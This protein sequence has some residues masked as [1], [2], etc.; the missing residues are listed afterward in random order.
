MV[1]AATLAAGMVTPMGRAA[2]MGAALEA[3]AVA[4]IYG[5]NPQPFEAF[6]EDICG[7]LLILG[8]TGFQPLANS[9]AAAR[10]SSQQPSS[11]NVMMMNVS[12]LRSAKAADG[13]ISC[14]Q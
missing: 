10:R 1:V 11:L 8:R 5:I 13:K 6:E 12:R 4:E 7:I 2:A 3:A 14:K 9:T